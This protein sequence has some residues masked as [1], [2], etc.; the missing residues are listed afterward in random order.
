MF[1]MYRELRG[2][3]AGPR[4]QP[5]LSALENMCKLAASALSMEP[6]FHSLTL[7]MIRSGKKKVKPKMKL[8]ATQGRRFVFIHRHMLAN[9]IKLD[10]DLQVVRLNCVNCNA[11][12]ILR[13]AHGGLMEPARGT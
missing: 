10:T 7:G 9:F 12:F 11:L 5:V 2:P 1:E 3:L 13:W 6:A 4:V 8:K